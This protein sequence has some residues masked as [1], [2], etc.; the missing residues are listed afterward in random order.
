MQIFL[1][2]SPSA[3]QPHSWIFFVE[4]SQK[5]IDNSQN[6]L[7]SLQPW[8]VPLN[9]LLKCINNIVSGNRNSNK[10]NDYTH[11]TC[12]HLYMC[13][14]QAYT[15]SFSVCRCIILYINKSTLFL[16]FTFQKYKIKITRCWYRW[17]VNVCVAWEIFILHAEWSHTF[18]LENKWMF[19]VGVTWG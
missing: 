13:I 9:S 8:N 5:F 1:I 19:K 6:M 2:I 16:C 12:T 10:S 17:K 7:V 11:S 14:K 4:K 15:Q 3:R 18:Y